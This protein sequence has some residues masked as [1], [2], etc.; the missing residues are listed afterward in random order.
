MDLQNKFLKF[1]TFFF[2]IYLQDNC[3]NICFPTATRMYPNRIKYYTYIINSSD[4]GITPK[5]LNLLYLE[6][7]FHYLPKRSFQRAAQQ[8]QI[9]RFCCKY[10]LQ[11]FFWR[12]SCKVVIT[13]DE[14][15]YFQHEESQLLNLFPLS[16]R[17]FARTLI[18][19]WPLAQN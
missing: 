9:N 19:H 2:K 3:L 11:N 6:V 18:F 16:T 10:Y 12:L 15:V 7:S 4:C 14:V 17:T 1:I 5:L 13:S 8:K